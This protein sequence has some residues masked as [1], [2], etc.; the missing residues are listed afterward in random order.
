MRYI[1]VLSILFIH[2]NLFGQNIEFSLRLE[3]PLDLPVEITGDPG[4]GQ[5]PPAA[6]FPGGMKAL[7]EYFKENGKL[8]DHKI[9]NDVIVF[10]EFTINEKGFSEGIRIIKVTAIDS[11]KSNPEIIDDKCTQEVIRLIW[12]MPKWYAAVEDG[13]VVKTKMIIPIFVTIK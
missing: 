7:D 4:Q 11:D 13:K 10:V 2:L 8:T 1:L 6:E 9:K 12:N 5:V 3:K